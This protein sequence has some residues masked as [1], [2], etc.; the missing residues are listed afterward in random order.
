[1]AWASPLQVPFR[2]LTSRDG[3][4]VHGELGWGEF[5]PFWDYDDAAA[6]KWWNCAVEQ[7]NVGWP[8]PVRTSI[9]VNVTVPAVAPEVARNLVAKGKGCRTAK[10]KVGQKI[11]GVLEPL[12]GEVARIAAVRET[13]DA[14]LGPGVG[15]IRV[16]ANGAWT[17]PE[18]VTHLR[19]L[20]CVAGGLEYAE[21]P[22]ATV[23]ELAE[24]RQALAAA[25]VNV[26]VAA[27][28]SVRR[29]EDPY[30]VRDLNA[31]DI[32]V[33]KVA[34][35]GGVRACLRLAEQIKLPVVVSSALES[36]IGLGAGLALAGC[37]PD[38]PFACGLAT[39]SLLLDDVVANPLQPEN[40][41]LPVLA[42]NDPRLAPRPD[43]PAADAELAARWQARQQRVAIMAG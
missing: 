32:V 30:L 17:V 31:A 33:L 8:T 22:C 20:D 37:L 25:K 18:A 28:E 34:P 14:L 9:P 42:A 10:V 41:Q 3:M 23:S 1:M 13:L 21:Q 29:A 36:S 35:L 38:L 12:D 40:G 16:D 11:N 4:S 19:E 39:S 7:A 24:L 6:A 5:S 26:L 27:D 43:F 15:R 2:N